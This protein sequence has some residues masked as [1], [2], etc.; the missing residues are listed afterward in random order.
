MTDLRTSHWRKAFIPLADTDVSDERLQQIREEV[1]REKTAEACGCFTCHGILNN[2]RSTR[3]WL[4]RET[5]P[6]WREWA[7]RN[8]AYFQEQLIWIINTPKFHK[9]GEQPTQTALSAT[10]I[11]P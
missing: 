9:K 10:A 3:E 8:L 4:R 11:K 6:R 1:R 7:K 2:I 5:R